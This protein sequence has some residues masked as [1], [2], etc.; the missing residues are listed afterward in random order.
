MTNDE[1]IYEVPPG[2]FQERVIAASAERPVIVDFWAEWCAPCRAFTPV[3]ERV[4]RSHGGRAALAKVN[5]E[6]DPEIARHYR[7]QSIPAVMVFSGGQVLTQFVGALPEPE[8]TRIVAAILPSA[9]DELVAQGDRLLDEG[10]RAK[11]QQRYEQALAQEPAHTGALLRLGRGAMSDNPEAARGHLSRIEEDAPEYA[12]AQGLL[13]RLEF[14]EVCRASGGLA[15]CCQRTEQ[16]ED[17]LDARYSLACCLAA[18]GEYEQALEALLGIVAADRTFRDNAARGGMVHI[19][20]LLGPDS[21][22]VKAFRKRLA[23]AL[24]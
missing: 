20:A 13:G 3:L 19:F 21:D 2:R 23:M 16:A 6:K 9:S 14:A 7:V 15:A 24:F 22:T 5:V 4:V 11:A 18:D 12:E 8:V 1:F 10:N 17:D